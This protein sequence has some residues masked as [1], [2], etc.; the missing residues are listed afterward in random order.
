MSPFEYIEIIPESFFDENSESLRLRNETA[1]KI[2]LLRGIIGSVKLRHVF[3]GN[4][5]EQ[6]IDYLDLGQS[7]RSI[8]PIERLKGYLFEDPDATMDDFFKLFQDRILLYQNSNFFKRLELEFN[9]FY[10][11][12]SKSSYTTAFAYIYRILEKISYAFPLIYA[13][14]TNDFEGT[15]KHLRDYFSG[16]NV[17]DK[18]KGELGFFKRFIKVVFKNDPLADASVTIIVEGGTDDVQQHF[19]QAFKKACPETSV[20]DSTDTY[21]PRRLSVKFT[22]FSSFIINIRNRFFHLLSSGQPNLQSEDIPDADH[23][24]KMINHQCMY[25]LSII[26]LEIFKHGLSRRKTTVT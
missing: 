18:Q 24:F 22:E 20:Y 4:E 1:S 26:T 11:Y 13:S 12:Q 23:F 3:T 14:K 17:G 2:L 8:H 7:R 9:N 21:E 6:Q 15:F 19:F 10:Y 5:F 25:W 16:I